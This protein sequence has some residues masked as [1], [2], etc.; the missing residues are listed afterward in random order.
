MDGDRSAKVY[1]KGTPSEPK[2]FLVKVHERPI[3]SEGEEEGVGQGEDPK[4]KDTYRT[5]RMSSLQY[6]FSSLELNKRREW[7]M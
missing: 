5:G 7:R 4:D 2:S 1:G 6:L 3:V